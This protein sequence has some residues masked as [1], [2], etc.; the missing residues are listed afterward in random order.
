MENPR[1]LSDEFAL[2]APSSLAPYTVP[3]VRLAQTAVAGASAY[4]KRP[5][6]ARTPTT[7]SRSAPARGR[8]A[9]RRASN[10]PP[11]PTRA[12]TSRSTATSNAST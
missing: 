6:S 9:S 2:V 5:N 12:A 11:S 1:K 7:V 4:S 10:A 3:G 8:A